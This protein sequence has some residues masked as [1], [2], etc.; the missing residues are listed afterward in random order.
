MNAKTIT[1]AAAAV[2]SMLI[3][4][5]AMAAA[6]PTS[7]VGTWSALANLS[8]LTVNITS[9][10]TKGSCPA[11]LGTITDNGTGAASNLQG[12]YCPK[13]GRIQ[14]LRKNPTSNDTFQV[15]NGNLSFATSNPL[16]G[17]T[18]AEDDEI[19]DLG[20]YNFAAELES[21]GQ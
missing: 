2:S 10:G 4:G 18:F 6:W 5:S 7:V 1:A 9:Q 15:Y 13:S 16:M 21:G 17:G 12:F 11:I 14:F 3:A 19:P 8:S 20:E